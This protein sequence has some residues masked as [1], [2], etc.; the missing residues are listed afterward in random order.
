MTTYDFGWEST[1]LQYSGFVSRRSLSD[2]DNKADND[3]CGVIMVIMIM[4]MMM[5]RRRMRSG[6][7]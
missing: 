7:G 1:D 5:R 4:I 3:G 2:A 6:E